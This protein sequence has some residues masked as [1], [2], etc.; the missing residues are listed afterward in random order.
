MMLEITPLLITVL[1]PDLCEI[2]ICLVQHWPLATPL[3]QAGGFQLLAVISACGPTNMLRVLHAFL[4][5]CVRHLVDKFVA[6][7]VQQL[8]APIS[9]C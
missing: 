6:W 7:L 1:L 2:W 9:A 5:L 8:P 4:T 3:L